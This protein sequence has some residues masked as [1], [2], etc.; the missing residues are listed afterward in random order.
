MEDDSEEIHSG[1]LFK[2][3]AERSAP[4]QNATLADWAA[5][6]DSSSKHY[7]KKTNTLQ[8]HDYNFPTESL[9]DDETNDDDFCDNNMTDNV[10]GKSHCVKKCT[11]SR[12]IRSV[13]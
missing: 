9:M 4:L 1:S 11:N 10:K 12:V 6:Y 2:R 8:I 5:W 13:V 7:R 3:Y